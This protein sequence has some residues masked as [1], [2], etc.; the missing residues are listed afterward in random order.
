MKRYIHV[1]QEGSDENLF[2]VPVPSLRRACQYVSARVNKERVEGENIAT[3]LPSIF[4][5]RRGN[6]NYDDMNELQEKGFDVEDDNLPNPYNVLEPTHVAINDPPVFNWKTDC[7]FCPRRA[8]NIKNSL[9]SFRNYLKADIMKM[10]RLD[11]FLTMM[12]M[13]CIEDTV[14]KKTNEQLDVPMTTQEYIKLVGCW[15]YMSCW[16]G[17]LNQR[18]W[19]SIATP[20]RHNRAPF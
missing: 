20:S 10:S 5:G 2:D 16:V 14:I 13:K 7:I 9:S 8:A 15:I 12:P 19:W 4:F 1:V 3:D 11:M 6:L 17:I 18:Y